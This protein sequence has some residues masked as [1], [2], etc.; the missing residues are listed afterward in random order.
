MKIETVIPDLLTQPLIATNLSLKDKKIEN[1]NYSSAF[2]VVSSVGAIALVTL[3]AALALEGSTNQQKSSFNQ[4]PPLFSILDTGKQSVLIDGLPI[5]I[6]PFTQL[7][8]P[9]QD[10]L[11]G[12]ECIG[13]PDIS[14][15]PSCQ[16]K[17]GWEE[18]KR[19]YDK[20][21]AAKQ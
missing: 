14:A 8:M 4:H 9:Y 19:N 16:T 20:I 17:E 11:T 21:V 2:K 7:I 6:H 15:D 12:F 3:V 5:C 13:C 10:T 1:S 18:C